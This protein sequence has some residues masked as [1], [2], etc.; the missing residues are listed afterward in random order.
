MVHGR[1]AG[2]VSVQRVEC[3][4]IFC[5]DPTADPSEGN[6]LIVLSD[7][8]DDLRDFRPQTAAIISRHTSDASEG[9]NRPTMG[10]SGSAA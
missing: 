4:L 6:L 10:G 9:R 7:P 1:N 8:G 2:K 3:S 5:D